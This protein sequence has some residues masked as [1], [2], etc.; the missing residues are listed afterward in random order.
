MATPSLPLL[1]EY[2]LHNYSDDEYQDQEEGLLR[3]SPAPRVL[4]VPSLISFLGPRKLFRSYPLSRKRGPKGPRNLALFVKLWCLMWTGPLLLVL[5]VGLFMPSYVKYPEWYR[6]DIRGDQTEGLGNPGNEKI[7]IAANII[8]EDLIRGR[9]GMAVKYLIHL[10]GSQNC[11]LSVY[12]NDSGLGTK[13]AL[14]EFRDS[15]SSN[16]SIVSTTLPLSY[17][18]TINPPFI[19]HAV[20]KRITYLATVR[21]L[22]L[23]PL[24]YALTPFYSP[25][26]ISPGAEKTSLENPD[27][28][29]VPFKPTGYSKV[30][31]LNDVVFS[32]QEAIHLLFDTNRGDYA[33]ACA[34]D[35]INPIKYYD[36]FALRDTE[37]NGIGLPFYPF[38]TFG[39]SRSAVLAG[40]ESIPVKSCWGGM[41]AFDATYFTRHE[42][43]L[44]PPVRFRSEME[45]AWDASEC[46]LIHA[47]IADPSRTFL[48]P[49][50]RTSY[51]YGTF[52]LLGFA[53]R[54]EKA[55]TYPHRFLSWIVG[56]PWANLRRGEKEG[57]R[58]WT[59]DSSGK[60]VERIAKKGGFCGIRRL[61]VIEEGKGGARKWRK[62]KLPNA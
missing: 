26:P 59:V 47:D 13:E 37:G 18:P 32:P 58:Y 9:W 44:Q 52:R 43:T 34:L 6:D 1:D 8:N 19:G 40:R 55:W 5:F 29:E 14:R 27:F 56:M 10:L 2:E 17:I 11:F 57:E 33:A 30:L 24:T 16:A 45:D 7:F 39:E 28:H 35:F 51:D 49:Y 22:A 21:N 53:R 62:W 46:C 38:F 12:E 23:L 31:F 54:I 25:T 36:T 50:I 60:K 41:V 15:I 48:N 20:T 4:S 3:S 61:Q 42:D